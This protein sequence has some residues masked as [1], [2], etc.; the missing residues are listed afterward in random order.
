MNYTKFQNRRFRRLHGFLDYKFSEFDEYLVSRRKRRNTQ[1]KDKETVVKSCLC[2]L[3]KTQSLYYKKDNS[4]NIKQLF[5]LSAHSACPSNTVFAIFVMK[6]HQKKG[7]LFGSS[8]SFPYLC[9]RFAE[10]LEQRVQGQT[11]LSLAEPW[12]K[13]SYTDNYLRMNMPWRR[14]QSGKIISFLNF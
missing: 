9:S 14:S 1:K 8:V 5:I 11:G 12:Q 3:Q 6:N 13:L 2:C 4:D 7:W 10:I